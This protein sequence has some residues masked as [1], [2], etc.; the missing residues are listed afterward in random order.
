MTTIYERAL[1]AIEEGSIRPMQVLNSNRLSSD[2]LRIKVA[3]ATEAVAVLHRDGLWRIGSY[4]TYGNLQYMQP[5]DG[6]SYISR[7]LSGFHVLDDA[8]DALDEFLRGLGLTYMGSE[9]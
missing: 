4:R 9:A 3:P 7:D 1:D 6:P 5:D 8:A 2:R